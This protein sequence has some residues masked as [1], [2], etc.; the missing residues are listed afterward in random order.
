[1]KAWRSLRAHTLGTPSLEPPTRAVVA[2][3]RGR[4][5]V[6]REANQRRG[7]AWA[8]VTAGRGLQ[9]PFDRRRARGR[10]TRAGAGRARPRGAEGRDGRGEG[11]RRGL[12]PAEGCDPARQAGRAGG[13][14]QE[15][16]L[17]CRPVQVPGA[18]VARKQRLLRASQSA[19]PH[20]RAGG[21]E[22]HEPEPEAC[23][24]VA[25][26]HGQRRQR[27]RSQWGCRARTCRGPRI[28]ARGPKPGMP[29]WASPP[30]CVCRIC[31]RIA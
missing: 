22:Q 14:Q 11:A 29:C 20:H 13:Q 3:C 9:A 8:R 12:Y 27:Q 5:Q 28:L 15:A 4:L 25:V 6:R 16:R 21:P 1:M 30:T 10:P 2:A 26:R 17:S 23:P 24:A 19:A 31:R 18:S 7:R